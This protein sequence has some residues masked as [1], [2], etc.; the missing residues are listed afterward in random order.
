MSIPFTRTLPYVLRERLQTPEFGMLVG[1]VTAIPDTTHVTVDFGAAGQVT[2]ARLASYTPTVGKPCY[3]LVAPSQV[4]AIGDVGGIA[5]SGTPGPPGTPGER[6]FTGAGVPPAGPVGNS[7][8]G[9]WYL[10]S[11]N[12]DYYEQTTATAW[13]L[14]GNLRGP[15]GTTGAQGPAGATGAQG[16]A[17]ATGSQGPQGATGAQGPKGDTG[18]QGPAGAQGPQGT[19][20]AQGPAGATGPAGPGVPAGGATGQVLTKTSG[21]DYATGWQTPSGGGS[22]LKVVR[23]IVNGANGAIIAGTGFTVVRNGIGQYTVTYSPAFT[24]TPVVVCQT[25]PGNA[26]R[27][28]VE[29]GAQ[30]AGSS[31]IYVVD[32]TGNFVDVTFHFHA[33]EP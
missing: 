2:I 27:S 7:I 4:L 22:A 17:G 20:G 25:A 5:S 30:A 8:V 33:I 16:P 28:H 11:A 19:T 10:N 26:T 15:T 9:D 18:A 23:G 32:G 6:W 12:G 21:A 13:A 29:L 24:V 1:N 14:R 3:C 31:V